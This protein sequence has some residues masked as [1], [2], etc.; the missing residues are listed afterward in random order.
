ML[1]KILLNILIIL[2]GPIVTVFLYLASKAE[3]KNWRVVLTM[4]FV[5]SIITVAVAIKVYRSKEASRR[6]IV[7]KSVIVSM[8]LYTVL[9]SVFLFLYD[10]SGAGWLIVIIPFIIIFSS[11][12]AFS[13]SYGVV[14]ILSD[15]YGNDENIRK[16]N[17]KEN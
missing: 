5:F 13:I 6:I 16:R 11:P 15:I 3:I 9:S 8:T 1:L 17:D 2:G 4:V 10:P 7:G 12:M 14:R